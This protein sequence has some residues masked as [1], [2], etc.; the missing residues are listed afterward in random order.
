M[1]FDGILG[2]AWPRI[3]VDGVTPVF[4]QML[5][6]GV[7]TQAESMFG[8]WLNRS[9]TG[10]EPNPSGGQL[11]LGGFDPDHY[12][13]SLSW[14]NLTNE[15]YWEFALD[16][17]KVG[18][19]TYS[20]NAR[21]ICDTGTS[22]LA[23]PSSVMT[24]VNKALGTEG[25]LQEECD[26]IIDQDIDEIV[27]WIKEGENSTQI[28]TNLGLCPGG[29]LCG[30]CSLVFGVLDEILPSGAGQAVIKYVLGEICAALPEPN[31]EAVVDCTKVANLPDVTFTIAGK[32]YTLTPD[33]YI[34]K[35][36][37]GNTT[38]CLSGFIG[39]DL[40][41]QVGPLFILGDVFIGAN[42]AAFDVA[43]KRV[44]FAPAKA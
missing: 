2:F 20:T 24:A 40:P 37:A 41:P 42:Y 4:N 5:A 19:T 35:S 6:Q 38:I 18:D 22:L 14:V 13:G 8:F 1:G 31:G 33:Q 12:E 39:L 16:S 44:G 36:G 10:G 9:A 28:C 27:Q 11:T 30:V 34:L 3:A 21:A 43:N 29:S 32:D 25:L 17:M 15:T 23:G 7:L 26:N